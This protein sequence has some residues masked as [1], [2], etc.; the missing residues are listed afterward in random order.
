MNPLE[1]GIALHSLKHAPQPKPCVERACNRVLLSLTQGFIA[2]TVF[3]VHSGV[4]AQSACEWPE[5][6]PVPSVQV[7]TIGAVMEQSELPL[8]HRLSLSTAARFGFAPSDS[9]RIG[10]DGIE[11]E[12]G[13]YGYANT[14]IDAKV[15]PDT[16]CRTL[17]RGGWS[18]E[19]KERAAVY[20]VVDSC[21]GVTHRPK[22]VF[23]V[24]RQKLPASAVKT[25]SV[26]V[27]EPPSVLL[28]LVGLC[29]LLW[30]KRPNK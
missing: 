5:S 13:L 15:S 25:R 6:E 1:C 14:V 27:P 8:M 28:A 2:T 4:Y 19:R 17:D 21:I 20:C 23:R 22:K 30:L 11:S 26:S 16:S 18:P 9:I 29:A 7:S 24:M 3:L 12:S 10:R